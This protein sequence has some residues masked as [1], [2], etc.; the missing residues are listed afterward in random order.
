MD[1]KFWGL[2]LMLTLMVKR[3][4]GGHG[5]LVS[6]LDAAGLQLLRRVPEA[7]VV[8]VLLEVSELRR[9]Q[10]PVGRPLGHAAAGAPVQVQG[11]AHVRR[12]ALSWRRRHSCRLL[13]G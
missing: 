5:W 9:H 12:A 10:P 8:S 6:V 3:D 11:A 2:T 1:G 4:T 7:V 13:I